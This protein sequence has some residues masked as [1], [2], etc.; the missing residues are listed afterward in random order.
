MKRFELVQSDMFP[1]YDVKITLKPSYRCNQKCWYCPEYDN[2]SKM[3]TLEDCNRVIEKLTELPS[4]FER[5]FIYMYGGEPTLSKYWEYI[6]LRLSEAFADRQVYFQTQTNMSIKPDRLDNFLTE[7]NQ[8]K[9]ESHE[10][11]ICSSYHLGKQNVNDF[12]DK[13]NICETHNSMGYCFF[14]TEI[15]KEKQTIAEFNAIEARFPGMC[16][17]K[18][19]VIPNLTILRL[20]GYTHLFDDEYLVGDDKGEYIEYRYFLRKYPHLEQHLEHGWTFSVDDEHMNYAD[21][22]NRKIYKQ[23]KYKKCTA[24]RKGV[25][26]DHNLLVYHCNDDFEMGINSTGIT[27]LDLHTYLNRD[28]I[29]LNCSCWDG[30]DFKKYEA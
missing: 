4:R 16:K 28:A 30:L 20:P 27:E 8:Q 29:C 5:L 10:V 12:I 9:S 19:T 15:P 11:N 3:W 2:K 14:S 26:V 24:G 13:M 17:L 21:V 6:Q 7:F 1:R 25:V 18:F 23:F 22:I